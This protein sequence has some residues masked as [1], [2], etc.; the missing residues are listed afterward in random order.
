MKI[1]KG[2][3]V[4]IERAF[5]MALALALALALLPSA[6][7]ADTSGYEGGGSL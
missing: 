3:I 4:R 7:F 1:A 6:A 5:A 2:A